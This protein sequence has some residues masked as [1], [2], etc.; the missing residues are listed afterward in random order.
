MNILLSH[1]TSKFLPY[2]SIFIEKLSSLLGSH[3]RCF[4]PGQTEFNNELYWQLSSNEEF[5]KE[6][7]LIRFWH[8]ESMSAAAKAP[9]LVIPQ[10]ELPSKISNVLLAYSSYPDAEETFL[11]VGMDIALRLNANLHCLKIVKPPKVLWTK[12]QYPI[13][14]ELMCIERIS[15]HDSISEGV[16]EYAR[17]HHI[18]LI[19]L[20]T[21]PWQNTE[22][23]MK[24]SHSMKILKA[25]EVPVL[26]FRED[27]I[28]GLP[29]KKWA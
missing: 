14:D 3:S 23:D 13:T 27:T 7:N 22:H 16:L 19:A 21:R 24:Y 10:G 6:E 18:D 15:T 8:K 9:Q 29:L 25:T 5:L 28:Q 26:L 4:L 12:K 17:E 2:Q 11:R 20:L 1:D